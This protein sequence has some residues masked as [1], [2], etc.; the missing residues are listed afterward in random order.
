MSGPVCALE[1]NTNSSYTRS[2]NTPDVGWIS[3]D[4]WR[5]PSIQGT[6]VSLVSP[7]VSGNIVYITTGTY[8]WGYLVAE[9]I[10]KGALA[11]VI[12]ETFSKVAGGLSYL[13]I[14]KNQA[15]ELTAIP[16]VEA[17]D[18][19]AQ[20]LKVLNTPKNGT[21]PSFM[22][23]LH[24]T[25]SNPWS[26]INEFGFYYFSV[27][28]GTLAVAAVF[29]ACH[30]LRIIT[31]RNGLKFSLSHTCLIIE[32]FANTLR[33]LYIIIDPIY[34]RRIFPKALH[35]FAITVLPSLSLA[36]SV[37][38]A[39]Y[40]HEMLHNVKE[41]RQH[42]RH[43]VHKFLIPCVSVIFII[44]LVDFSIAFVLAFGYAN[45]VYQAALALYLIATTCVVSYLLFN[46]TRVLIA[47]YKVTHK[48]P[49]VLKI[50]QI[51]SQLMFSAVFSILAMII[52]L[53]G[54]APFFRYP[55]GWFF[56]WSCLWICIIAADITQITAIRRKPKSDTVPLEKVNIE[57]RKK[58]KDTEIKQQDL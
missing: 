8:D 53:M 14:N 17:G 45:Y 26:G 57:T 40:W 12:S 22:V 10:D 3:K 37:I 16:T 28:A 52:S 32:I 29:I 34:S 38:I 44:I 15:P 7:N 49:E 19:L 21:Y 48:T 50:K 5:T 23:T 43:N 2:F 46:G 55:A 47:L 56:V 27:I 42:T 31:K 4:A 6:I 33:A 9:A 58:K 41:L 51:T 39:F 24:R 35:D 25:D 18:D 30:K 11:L 54:A 13:R 1:L 20:I 36:T